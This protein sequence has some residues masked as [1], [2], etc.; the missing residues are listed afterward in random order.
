MQIALDPHRP[1]GQ[2]SQGVGR[3]LTRDTVAPNFTREVKISEAEGHLYQFLYYSQNQWLNETQRRMRQ[4]DI[5][6]NTK[7]I[8]EL[9]VNTIIFVGH[10][11][12]VNFRQRGKFIN[13]NLWTG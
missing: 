8:G 1:L 10:L 7:N 6:F 11:L 12:E 13:A 4:A 9:I 2:G 3:L 5:I